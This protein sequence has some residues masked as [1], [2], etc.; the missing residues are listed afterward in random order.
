MWGALEPF[1]DL[2]AS[3]LQQPYLS[4]FALDALGKLCRAHWEEFPGCCS[5]TAAALRLHFMRPDCGYPTDPAYWPHANAKIVRKPARCCAELLGGGFQV[6]RHR[7]S[8]CAPALCGRDWPLLFP[9]NADLLFK[10]A[11]SI[12]LRISM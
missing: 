8:A 6:V 7:L 10:V 5:G 11:P 12:R 1:S 3:H 2:I 4:V 9:V